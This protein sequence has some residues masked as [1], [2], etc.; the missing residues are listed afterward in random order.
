MHGLGKEFLLLGNDFSCLLGNNID[1]LTRETATNKTSLKDLYLLFAK[2]QGA[3][4]NLLN[5]SREE[6]ELEVEVTLN[7]CANIN[8]HKSLFL[9]SPNFLDRTTLPL[10]AIN[11][12]SDD[13]GVNYV[14]QRW[15]YQRAPASH[16]IEELVFNSMYRVGR[17]GVLSL[18]NRSGILP[19]LSL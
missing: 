9:T 11:P 3:A 8:H 5:K 19:P 7:N 12:P 15:R 16:H 14:L 1:T 6:L 2:Y 18:L 17:N 4:R 10:I 13:N